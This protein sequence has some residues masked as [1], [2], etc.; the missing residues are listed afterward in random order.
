MQREICAQL[1]MCG[2]AFSGENHVLWLHFNSSIQ[3]ARE[4]TLMNNHS[5]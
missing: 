1:K 3:H 4:W 5:D 2:G